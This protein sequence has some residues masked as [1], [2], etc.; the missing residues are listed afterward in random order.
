MTSKHQR[1]IRVLNALWVLG[2]GGIE[3]MLINVL[4]RLDPER[5]QMDFMVASQFEAHYDETARALGARILLGKQVNSLTRTQRELTSINRRFGPYDV[6]HSHRHYSGAALLRA[7]H[8]LGIPIRIAHGHAIRT[9]VGSGIDRVGFSLARYLT[10]KHCTHGLAVS[11][12]AATSLFGPS[13]ER[14]PKFEICPPAVDFSVFGDN[15]TSQT[16]R[17]DLGISDNE[18][19]IAHVGR[20]VESKNHRFIIAVAKAISQQSDRHRFVLIGDGPLL[21]PIQHLA[22]YEGLGERVLFLGNRS[23]IAELLLA[24]DG[25]IFPS[26]TE[27]L[28]LAAVEAQAAGLA[29]FFSSQVVPEVD[30]VPELLC[31]LPLDAGPRAWA[32]RI[33]AHGE[34][35]ISRSDAL[36]RCVASGLNIDTYT[37]R[38]TEIYSSGP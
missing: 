2:I 1:P 10:R 21:Q 7:A 33:L 4:R 30:I 26:L 25:F 16:I 36:A 14:H 23:D 31:R 35:P 32:D 13:W 3:S 19:A 28:G 6:V 17:R 20:F 15:S 22:D 34:A 9:G 38:L 11:R 5:I 37:D 18:I 27:A 12:A 24:M 8:R 29:C